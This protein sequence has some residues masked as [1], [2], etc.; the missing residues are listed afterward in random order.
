VA[1]EPVLGVFRQTVRLQIRLHSRDKTKGFS[2]N[3]GTQMLRDLQVD[4]NAG[5]LRTVPVDSADVHQRAES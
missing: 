1:G 5:T 3:E 4:L 2:Q